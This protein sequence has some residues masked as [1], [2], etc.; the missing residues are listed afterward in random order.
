MS[1]PA[2]AAFALG[3]PKVELHVH[4]E[5]S[6][7]PR[8]LLELARR[9]RVSLPAD[10]AAGLS[11]WFQFQGFP[12]FIEVYLACS[13]CLVEPEDFHRLALDF[14][15]EQARQNVAWSEVHFSISTH[16]AGGRDGEAIRQAL[17]EAAAEG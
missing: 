10:D 7:Q 13:S 9:R 16:L 12:H 17:A 4:L 3:L 14:L 6:I 8:T 15:A 11:R 1:E 2:L 5:G